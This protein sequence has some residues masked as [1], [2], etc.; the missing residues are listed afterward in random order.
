MRWFSLCFVGFMLCDVGHA[1]AIDV[2]STF[3]T[4]LD[5]WTSTAPAEIAWTADGGNSGGYV[6]FEDMSSDWTRIYAPPKFLGDW[7]ALN[8]T[9][10]LSFDH[11]LFDLGRVPDT[12]AWYV[13]D[14]SG[15]GG[16]TTFSQRFDPV[17][18]TD[19]ISVEVPILEAEWGLNEGTWGGL[20]ADVTT[21]Q[22]RIEMVL[23]SSQPGDVCGLDNVRLIP[24]PSTFV[25]LLS[26]APMAYALR[27]RL[28]S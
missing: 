18:P 23:N 9:G 27:R 21:L 14:M 20:L 1:N 24:E 25:L 2:E 13:V 28:V 11:R 8:G 15:L 16:D 22:L 12:V 17:T 7:S 26:I 6:R 5:G 10:L 3:D 19:W 4:D